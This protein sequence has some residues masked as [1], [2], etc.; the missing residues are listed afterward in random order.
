ESNNKP[1]KTKDNHNNEFD[2]KDCEKYKEGPWWLEKS[3]IWVNL[4]GK[5]LKEKTSDYGGIYWYTW[6]TSYRVTL[7][8]T[9][10]MIRRII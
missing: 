2:D 6:Q 5:Y 1:F 3:C 8:K 10:M 7:K 9:T 4:N